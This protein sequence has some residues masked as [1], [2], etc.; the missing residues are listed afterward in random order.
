METVV[1][2]LVVAVVGIIGTLLSPIV[3]GRLTARM[4]RELAAQQL[5]H[6][7]ESRDHD[8]RRALA[9]EKRACYVTVNATARW[10]RV[11]QMNYL[12]AV[13]EG[14]LREEDRGEF[15]AAR[16]AYAAAVAEAQIL[17]SPEV[18][19]EM[20]II[21]SGL[22][23]TFRRIKRLELGDPEPDGSFDDIALTCYASGSSG[24]V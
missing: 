18:L 22:S 11:V 8:E 1:S 16:R 23:R 14:R 15:E 7:R 6:A 24:L 4:Q 21:F 10:Y 17:G 3:S 13:H 5:Q 2:P 19:D 20:E 9:A 12:H